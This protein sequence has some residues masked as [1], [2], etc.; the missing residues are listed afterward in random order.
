MTNRSIISNS[1]VLFVV[2]IILVSCTS[3]PTTQ[4][5]PT[6]DLSTEDTGYPAPVIPIES[7]YPAG[8]QPVQNTESVL[9]A[10]QDP[11]L[12]AVTGIMKYKG[13]PVDGVSL[14]LANVIKN[15]QGTEIATSFDRT[16][17]PQANTG[18]DGSFAFVNV[19][20]GRYGLIYAN[21]PET[22]LLL[23][24]GD[25]NIVQAILV[26]VEA[27]QQTDIGILDFDELPEALE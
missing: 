5:A 8:E 12:G 6:N 13:K 1:V 19:K 9:Q 10:T 23:V 16:T 26:S 27:G 22:Y 24:P 4:I 15:A 2:F 17:A 25:P 18:K 21:L 3:I 14:G 20:P 11:Q 7:V